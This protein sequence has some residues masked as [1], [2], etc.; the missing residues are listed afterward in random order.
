MIQPN[1]LR[2]GNFILRGS[3]I[4]EVV[5]IESD[6]LTLIDSTGIETYRN[7]G[8][9]QPI[10]LTPEWLERCGFIDPPQNGMAHRRDIN[11]ADEFCMYW[12][13]REFRYQTQGAGFTRILPVYFVH[14]VQNAFFA[15]TGQE[16]KVKL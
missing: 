14:Q 2:I 13:A 3:L 6:D 10:S 5:G 1:E 8:D 15:L 9:I 16:L 7:D 12:I 4:A 11:G